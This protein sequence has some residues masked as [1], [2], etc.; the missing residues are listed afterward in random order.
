MSKRKNVM[1]YAA[2]LL[3]AVFVAAFM[4]VAFEANHDCCGDGCHIC[5][6]VNVIVGVTKLLTFIFA[7]FVFLAFSDKETAKTVTFPKK[8]TGMRS[9]VEL[10][11]KLSD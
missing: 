4:F 3:A 11:V 9:L 5:A 2:I 10:N 8:R 1:K 6:A 7:C